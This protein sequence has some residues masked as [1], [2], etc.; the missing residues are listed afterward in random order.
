VG[1]GGAQEEGKPRGHGGF[2]EQL[3]THSEKKKKGRRVGRGQG[4]VR[5]K[6]I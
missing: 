3:K 6:K 1:G 5:E 2:E 4:A